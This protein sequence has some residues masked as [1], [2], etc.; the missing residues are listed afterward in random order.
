MLREIVA[1]ARQDAPDECC[2]LLIGP[3]PPPGA[4]GP[5]LID[6][7]V[8]AANLERGPA[9]YRVDPAQH[10][11]LQKRLR[12]TG[13]IIAGAYHSHP[14]TDAVPSRSDLDEAFY[15]D[16]VY[17]IVSLKRPRG[18]VVRAWRIRDAAATE[19]TIERIP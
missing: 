13:R 14:R 18:P 8:R 3:A 1:H 12:G 9:R 11:A 6:E 5:A 15:P 2:G 10:V 19:M 16:F 17:V 4:D 7:A